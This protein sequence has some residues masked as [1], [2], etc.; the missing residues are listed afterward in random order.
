ML[1]SNLDKYRKDLDDLLSES[2]WVKYSLQCTAI[3]RA[4]FHA[5]IT[6]TLDGDE[7]K[8]EVFMNNIKPFSNAYQQWYTESLSLVK[9]LLPDRLSDFIRLYEKPKAR[10]DITFEN[11]RIEDAC[12]GLRVS[13]AGVVKADASSASPL[14]EQQVAIVEAIKRRFE[15]SLFDIKQ[16]VQADLFDSELD[17]AKGLLKSGFTRAAGAI[18]GVVLEGHLKQLRDKYELPIKLSTIGP[19]T[20]ALKAA[21]IIE[22]S[23]LRHIQLLGDF[24]TKCSHRNENEPTAEEVGELI[25]GVEKVIK[26]IF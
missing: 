4:E 15:S 26:T 6:Q 19:I 3:G 25:N 12:Q 16:L 7:K 17:T 13:F 18:A 5:Q 1:I 10:K 21:D 9:Q 8:A 22:L 23:Q 11:Y 20:D 24:R 14:L 2:V